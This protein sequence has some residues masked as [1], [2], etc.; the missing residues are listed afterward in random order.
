MEALF[1]TRLMKKVTRLTIQAIVGVMLII[2]GF[3]MVSFA[4]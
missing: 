1:C 4:Q 2:V 3:I